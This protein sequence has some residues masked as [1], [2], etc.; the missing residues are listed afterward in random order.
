MLYVAIIQGYTTVPLPGSGPQ[1]QDLVMLDK[2]VQ[3]VNEVRN[4]ILIEFF[5][6]KDSIFLS[7]LGG[8]KGQEGGEGQVSR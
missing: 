1:E 6:Q 4:E 3:K 7:E 2:L 5:Q 8:A